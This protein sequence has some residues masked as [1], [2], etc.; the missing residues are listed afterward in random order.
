MPF[1]KVKLLFFLNNDLEETGDL[2]VFSI[3]SIEVYQYVIDCYK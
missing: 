1:L 3:V 2:L